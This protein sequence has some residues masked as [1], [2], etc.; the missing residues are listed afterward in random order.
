[1]IN[2]SDIQ[3]KTCKKWKKPVENIW[4]S[5]TRL[6][7]YVP[8][9]LHLLTMHWMSMCLLHHKAIFAGVNNQVNLTHKLCFLPF[10]GW[11][12]YALWVL[13]QIQS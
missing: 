5:H 8:Y 10:E 7:P 13:G 6:L 1:M 3:N 11:E 4:T 9:G 2:M 12:N